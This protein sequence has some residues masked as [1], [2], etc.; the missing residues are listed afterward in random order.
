MVNEQLLMTK[1]INEFF[2]EWSKNEAVDLRILM[3]E[4]HKE[5][6]RIAL[7]LFQKE[8][9][10]HTWQVADLENEFYL[11]LLGGDNIE[12]KNRGHFF[13]YA[14]RKMRYIL[15]NKAYERC[16][17]KRGGSQS[18]VLVTNLDSLDSNIEI[19]IDLLDLEKLLIEL[20][21]EDEIAAKVVEMRFFTGLTMAEIAEAEG[22][23]ERTVF[24]Q[25]S[26]ARAWL[27]KRLSEAKKNI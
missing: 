18:P 26:W 27:H 19:P 8:A 4:I 13:A 22:L 17:E 23:S 21:D 10:F 25:W 7:C 15:V 12:W 20:G 9:Y 16:A 3:P 1:V 2:I 5:I 14:A 24:R 11:L 6:H